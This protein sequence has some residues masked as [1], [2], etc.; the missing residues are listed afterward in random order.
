[1]AEWCSFREREVQLGLFSD[2]EPS[3][4]VYPVRYADGDYFHAHAQLALCRKDFS[5]LNYPDE[6]FRQSAKYLEFD[7]LVTNM[8]DE[9]VAKLPTIPPWS[10]AFPVVEPPAPG[11]R[12][13]E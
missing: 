2:A 11:A 12:E 8:A 5:R 1:M 7:D 6:A 13:R 9:L 3:G 4:L 10:D